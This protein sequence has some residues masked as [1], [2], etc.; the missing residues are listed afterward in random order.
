MFVTAVC[1]F[2]S[3]IEVADEQ[4]YVNPAMLDLELDELKIGGKRE[5]ERGGCSNI[6][7]FF[8]S[9][10]S[11]RWARHNMSHND[12]TFV[13]ILAVRQYSINLAIKEKSKC[14]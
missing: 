13:S 6:D 14:V 9:A 5:A 7:F 4:E 11:R 12:K 2:P 3:E 10:L 1:F 8:V